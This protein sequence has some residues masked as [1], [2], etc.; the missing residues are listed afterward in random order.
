M[1][2]LIIPLQK[3]SEEWNKTTG[4]LNKEYG[5]GVIYSLINCLAFTKVV[6]EA[7][8]YVH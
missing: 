8:Q 4:N 7:R 3:R 2:C 6:P 5:K 1:D